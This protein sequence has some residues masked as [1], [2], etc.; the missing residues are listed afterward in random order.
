MGKT[1]ESQW[2]DEVLEQRIRQVMLELKIDRMPTR[3]EVFSIRF[4]D[5]LHNG[6]VRHGGYEYWAKKLGLQIKDSESKTGWAYEECAIDLL[7][8]KGYAVERMSRKCAYDILVNGA[9]KID[10][11]AGK[12][13]FLKGS[14][15]HSFGINKKVPVC[16]IYLVLAID[17]SEKIERTF[18]IPSFELKVVSMCIGKDSKYN[19]FIDQWGYIDKFDGFYKSIAT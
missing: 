17:E 16:D 12:P 18:V 19:K 4:N 6:V 5:P 3:S 8:G 14:R 13:W 2:T 10:V 11:K 9:V 1:H 7:K 15:L